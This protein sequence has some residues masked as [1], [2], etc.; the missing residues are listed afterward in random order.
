MQQGHDFKGNPTDVF[1][2]NKLC[3]NVFWCLSLIT[4]LI[5]AQTVHL[6]AA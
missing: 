2:K 1:E 3:F 6:S 5:T 4:A